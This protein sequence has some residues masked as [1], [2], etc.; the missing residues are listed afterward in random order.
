MLKH[1]F[2]VSRTGVAV[3]AA[4]LVAAP[5]V[6]ALEAKISGQ[7]NRAIMSADDGVNSELL[8]VDNDTSS[9]RFRFTGSEQVTD[10]L[11]AGLTWEVEFQSNP[12]DVV[13][14]TNRDAASPSFDERKMELYL[15]GNWGKATL[16]QGDGAAN[17]GIELDL[18]GTSLI[19]YAGNGDIGGSIAFNQSSGAAVG[20]RQIGRGSAVLSQQDFES[21]YDRIRYDSPALGPITIAVSQG[22]K[23]DVDATEIAARLNLDLGGGS[24]L[25]A[26]LGTSDLDT[27]PVSK[28]TTGGSVSWLHGSGLNLTFAFSTVDDAAPQDKDFQYFKVG[29]KTGMHA[30]ALDFAQGDDQQAVGGEGEMVGLGYVYTHK[31]LELYAG[32]KT[33][34]YKEPGATF[35]DIDIVTVGGRV[36]F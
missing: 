19:N 32:W 36:K 23:S 11:E 22:T 10:D 13:T 2:T 8:F 15:R 18:S 29:Y 24:K 16:G 27:A 3:G 35:R 30:V 1:P 6:S 31:M 9:T 33:Y 5:A 14:P 7:V 12:S 4:L 20:A 34:E 26:A 21:R 17:G 25:A 28:E